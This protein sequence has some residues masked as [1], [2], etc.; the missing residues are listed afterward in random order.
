MKALLRVVLP[1]VGIAVLF[2]D[3]NPAVA[4]VGALT[5][6]IVFA[7]NRGYATADRYLLLLFAVGVGILAGNRFYPI[8]GA[9]QAGLLCVALSG[10]CI[11]GTDAV[12][13]PPVAVAESV[14][15]A[16]APQVQAQVQ[17][18]T[19]VQARVQPQASPAPRRVAQQPRLRTKEM[20]DALYE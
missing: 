16:P 9:V 12:L 10:V 20:I 7:A 5:A 11:K 18:Q 15:F 3:L 1:V 4:V 19:Q 17:V 2:R 6:V 14:P 8:A 13:S